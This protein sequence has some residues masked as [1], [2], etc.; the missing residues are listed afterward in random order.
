MEEKMFRFADGKEQIKK[1]NQ[2]LCIA[3]TILYV[4]SYAI[5]FIS[6]LQKNRTGFYAISMLLVMITTVTIGFVTL[7]KDS[8]N[9][10]LR[11]YMMLG[12]CVVSAMLIA[13]YVDYYMRFLAV[14]PFLGCIL[15]FDT[16]F[17]NTAACIVA[18][19]NVSLTL[20]REFFLHTY[21][22]E[23]FV[24][25][26]VAG[27][28]VTVLMFLSVYLTKVGKAFN[29]DS[30]GRVQYDAKV[31]EEMLGEV[32][33]IADNVR[34]KTNQAMHLMDELMDSSE[35][36][37]RAV[38]DIGQSTA[39]T[40]LSVQ[41]QST[42]TQ[43]IQEHLDETLLRAKKM[44]EVAMESDRLN[45]ENAETMEKLRKEAEEL[46]ETNDAVAYAMAQLKQNVESVKAITKTIFDI[47]S[48]TNLLALNASIE[49]ARAGEA[50][51]GFAV[52]ADEIRN[53]S[54]QTRQETENIAGILDNLASNA[55]ETANAVEKS[56]KNGTAQE[57][58]INQIAAQFETVNQ[59]IKKLS[60]DTQEIETVIS[61]LTIANTEIVKEI[62]TL[63]AATE[64]VTASVQQSAE[65]TDGNCRNVSET[66]SVLEEI[67][68][69]SHGVDKYT[70]K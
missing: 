38:E 5:V 1:V 12:I 23:E 55:T 63:S 29:A 4:I 22:E 36:V 43:D 13:A 40:A 58:M 15:F 42:M 65:M 45:E 70:T 44:T 60:E 52:V 21:G 37:S 66:K 48:K 27:L 9:V 47:S 10:K 51:R 61:N 30:T 54:E 62:T 39:S 53:L 20:F 16:K 6:F 2:F 18:V 69:I 11:Y 68:T 17:M 33:Q 56:L 3:T 31:Q 26:L 35:T 50:G 64:E 19:E 14:M 28:A 32:L 7:K 67:L 57:K 24:P 46:L 25:N 41:N 59:N 34:T 49:S 8:G